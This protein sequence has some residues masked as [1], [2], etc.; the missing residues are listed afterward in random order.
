[1]PSSW[2][3][4]FETL[5]GAAFVGAAFDRFCA[6]AGD[7]RSSAAARRSSKDAATIHAY[8]FVRGIRSEREANMAHTPFVATGWSQHDIER[9][10]QGDENRARDLNLGRPK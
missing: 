3:P 4:G 8:G 1:M 6:A 10:S 2:E 7:G 5:S 9:E